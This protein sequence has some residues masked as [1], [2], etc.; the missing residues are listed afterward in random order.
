[1]NAYQIPVTPGVYPLQRLHLQ[2]GALVDT[3]SFLA[4]YVCRLDSFFFFQVN[5]QEISF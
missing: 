1:M 5:W 2:A 4:K 3:Q